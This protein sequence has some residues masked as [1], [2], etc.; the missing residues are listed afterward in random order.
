MEEISR[1]RHLER[2]EL[3]ERRV[4]RAPGERVPATREAIEVLC[5]DVHAAPIEVAGHVLPEVR[6]LEGG[7]DVVG[8]RLPLGI[9]V[10]EE[11][12]HDTPDRVRRAATVLENVR[13][14][15]EG[16]RVA[17][18][19]APEGRS[20]SRNGSSGRSW[21]AIVCDEGDEDGSPRRRDRARRRGGIPPTR[22]GARPPVVGPL[23]R[24]SSAPRAKA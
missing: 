17:G 5:R 11:S 9:A 12:E 16:A 10:P 24:E 3:P 20:R 14:G 18:R 13:E 19:V 15:R 2:E 8:A 21:R 4:G 7:A 6:Q 23:V 1:A 22:Q